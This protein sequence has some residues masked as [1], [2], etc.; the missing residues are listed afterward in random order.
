MWLLFYNICMHHCYFNVATFAFDGHWLWF[1][2]CEAAVLY[3]QDSFQLL[4]A[5]LNFITNCF[6]WFSFKLSWHCAISAGLFSLFFHF[7]LFSSQFF[8]TRAFLIEIFAL[9]SNFH[10]FIFFSLLCSI[11]IHFIYARIR[12]KQRNTSNSTHET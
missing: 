11:V 1:C 6:V 3:S 10:I 7:L 2:Q 8:Q 4:H 9:F 12:L 5:Y